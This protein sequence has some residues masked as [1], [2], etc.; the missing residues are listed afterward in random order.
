MESRLVSPRCFCWAGPGGRSRSRG[1]S[2]D[3]TGSW[4]LSTFPF[5]LRN[6]SGI[7]PLSPPRGGAGRCQRSL[8]CLFSSR[9][10]PAATL[11]LPELNLPLCPKKFHSLP[12]SQEWLPA[13]G[14]LR[15]LLV[16]GRDPAT[17]SHEST[18]ASCSSVL[19]SCWARRLF[20]C[21]LL[22]CCQILSVCER[23]L[24]VHMLS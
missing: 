20:A 23:F 5:C 18:V 24:D 12:T 21:A 17:R 3:Q 1:Q 22:L 6:G 10:A 15:E 16:R 4:L 13:L 19:R 8:R 2:R 14:A 9:R 7:E 11:A